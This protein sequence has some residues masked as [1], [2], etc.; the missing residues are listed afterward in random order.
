MKSTP[1]PRIRSIRTTNIHLHGYLL[2]RRLFNGLLTDAK[3]FPFL[4]I[5]KNPSKL[6]KLKTLPL[7][8]GY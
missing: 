8:Y 5:K 2:S 7:N 3:P 6:Q 4:N 1:S